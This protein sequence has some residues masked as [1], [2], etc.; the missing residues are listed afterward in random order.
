MN[1]NTEEA[2]EA[3]SE[4][5]A[6]GNGM[7]AEPPKESNATRQAMK[8]EVSAEIN[9]LIGVVGRRFD[10]PFNDVHII[11]SKEGCGRWIP[12]KKRTLEQL[13]L[14]KEYL[15]EWLLELSESKS[16]RG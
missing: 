6:S 5:P 15:D 16:A 12:L 8:D 14:T 11:A 13:N 3:P 4:T 7:H 1:L 2:N 10:I 9:H